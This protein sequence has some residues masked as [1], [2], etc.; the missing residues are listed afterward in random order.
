[1]QCYYMFYNNTVSEFSSSA[2]IGTEVWSWGGGEHGQLGHGDTLDR[3]HPCL[4][5]SLLDLQVNIFRAIYWN[6]ALK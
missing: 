1:M 2:C 6:V 3:P 4:V 5:S